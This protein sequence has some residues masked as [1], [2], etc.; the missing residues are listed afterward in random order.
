MINYF[1]FII[2]CIAAVNAFGCASSYNSN[3]GRR[4]VVIPIDKVEVGQILY[5]FTKDEYIFELYPNEN[6]KVT[7]EIKTDKIVMQ[8]ARKDSGSLSGRLAMAYDF[9]ANLYHVN[10]N[11]K[12]IVEIGLRKIDKVRVWENKI[13]GTDQKGHGNAGSEFWSDFVRGM[14]KEL[15]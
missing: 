1:P 9:S 15:Y 4:L 14:L 3:E 13:V 2:I 7:E 8:V 5:V 6:S 11:P 10:Y 12:H